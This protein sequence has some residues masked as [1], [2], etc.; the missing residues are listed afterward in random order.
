M[1]LNPC[2]RRRAV[3]SRGE[4]AAQAGARAPLLHTAWAACRA[5]VHVAHEVLHRWHLCADPC[6]CARARGGPVY[7]LA[8]ALR[9]PVKCG[10]GRAAP[11]GARP[12]S[13]G[14]LRDGNGSGRRRRPAGAPRTCPR[15][16][17][18][19]LSLAGLPAQAVVAQAKAV[20]ENPRLTGEAELRDD[21]AAA[22]G[23]GDGGG[24]GEQATPPSHGFDMGQ[25]RPDLSHAVLLQARVG[26]WRATCARARRSRS[27][28]AHVAPA[29]RSDPPVCRAVRQPASRRRAQ[30]CAAGSG[31]R[32]PKYP[33]LTRVAVARRCRSRSRSGRRLT[34]ASARTW[35]ACCSPRGSCRSWS[36]PAAAPARR[37]ARA[38]PPTRYRC[39]GPRA[40][41]SRPI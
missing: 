8:A 19:T 32:P 6:A 15:V 41:P 12:A 22:G 38:S 31:A 39:C 16:R 40:P 36:A 11:D 27:T 9:A 7:G 34:A 2:G 13:A 3:A 4:R 33:N 10:G 21:A 18:P 14:Q 17:A 25:A 37:C 24:G 20:L 28:P 23:G 35:R 26:L 30:P 29:A 5:E 1:R